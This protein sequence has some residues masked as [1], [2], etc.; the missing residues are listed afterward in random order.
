M[1]TG[2]TNAA[3]ATAGPASPTAGAETK[4]GAESA[5]PEGVASLFAAIS[6]AATPQVLP[7]PEG[8]K[9][10]VAQPVSRSPSEEAPQ[11]QQSRQQLQTGQRQETQPTL[12]PIPEDVGLEILSPPAI[13]D[14]DAHAPGV[15]VYTAMDAE[16]A[17]EIAQA[18]NSG[19]IMR[20]TAPVPFLP[21]R[22]RWV[23]SSVA[24]AAFVSAVVIAEGPAAERGTM[25]YVW[26]LVGTSLGSFPVA[27]GLG[28]GTASLAR[29]ARVGSAGALR[30]S[31][32]AGSIGLF[33]GLAM[34]AE[35]YVNEYNAPQPVAYTPQP[36]RKPRVVIVATDPEAA[37]HAPVTQEQAVDTAR[38]R[39]EQQV[40]AVASAMRTLV[41]ELDEEFAERQRRM[42]KDPVRSLLATKN[43]LNSRNFA[44]GKKRIELLK[45]ISEDYEQRILARHD[46]FP[47]RLR[48]LNIPSEAKKQLMQA[49]ERTRAAN[50]GKLRESMMYDRAVIA[51]VRELY[52][53]VQSR[54]GKFSV[55]NQLWFRD[56]KDAAIYNSLVKRIN[57]LSQQQQRFTQQ[58]HQVTFA[59][60]AEIGNDVQWAS[61]N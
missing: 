53:F 24:L 7:A 35:H 13:P 31:F 8:I 46:H 39:N 25:Q 54:V 26:W 1:T 3:A 37:V 9:P 19:M 52:A 28:L 11:P 10:V 22:D 59:K 16:A 34:V 23:W 56:P 44:E 45:R 49:F 18:I 27:F 41:D 15:G 2:T 20:E 6:P 60:L 30:L 40:S 42:G 14:S 4:P 5:M 55:S 38:T 17:S 21:L 48:A 43:F 33:L 58:L 47:P 36:P 32:A 61:V 51:E 50:V 29:L 57:E 12:P